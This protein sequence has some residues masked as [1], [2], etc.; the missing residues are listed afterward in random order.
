[1][2]RPK[3]EWTRSEA[4]W[5]KKGLGFKRLLMKSAAKEDEQCAYGEPVDV[6]I[7]KNRNGPSHVTVHLTF[8]KE[9]TRFES[10]AKVS[11]DDMPR[12]TEEAKPVYAD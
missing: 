1:M 12:D 7:E 4:V 2:F 6:F 5:V 10:A 9:F 3:P 8:L 11:D